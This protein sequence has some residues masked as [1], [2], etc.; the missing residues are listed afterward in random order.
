MGERPRRRPWQSVYWYHHLEI[1]GELLGW[2]EYARD[3]W[4]CQATVTNCRWGS[5]GVTISPAGP[6]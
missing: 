3:W 5:A 2:E 1:P 4:E 6:Q